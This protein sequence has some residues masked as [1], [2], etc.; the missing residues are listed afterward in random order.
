MTGTVST[1]LRVCLSGSSSTGERSGS[2]H[3]SASSGQVE[4]P[5]Q[6][7]L[8]HAEM[9][10]G[11][12]FGLPA[13]CHS[14][15]RVFGD[16]QDAGGPVL[17]VLGSLVPQ[18]AAVIV[19]GRLRWPTIGRLRLPVPRRRLRA[20]APGRQRHRPP[21]PQTTVQIG[22]KVQLSKH[23]QEP[24]PPIA[25]RSRYSLT[26]PASHAGQLVCWARRGGWPGVFLPSNGIRG[27]GVGPVG[28]DRRPV[29]GGRRPDHG[30]GDPHGLGQ[31]PPDS[32]AET[33]PQVARRTASRTGE[34]VPG[35]LRPSAVTLRRS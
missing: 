9:H 1:P 8:A 15:R 33:R 5:S 18:A 10:G 17:S 14:K 27:L 20:G 13:A 22:A 16:E 30:G 24:P 19:E 28:V 2:L 11:F 35:H 6:Q 3:P 29:R 12:R 32:R 7:L 23:G 34:P 25:T 4:P 26:S 31:S 21:M